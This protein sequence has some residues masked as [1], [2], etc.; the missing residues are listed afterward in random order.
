MFCLI[1]EKPNTLKVAERLAFSSWMIKRGDM[2]LTALIDRFCYIDKLLH[3][4][5]DLLKLVEIDL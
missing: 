3:R 4:P 5:Y 2:R 1:K